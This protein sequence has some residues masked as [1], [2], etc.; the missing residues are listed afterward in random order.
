MNEVEVEY[1]INTGIIGPEEGG[2]ADYV[3]QIGRGYTT[4]PGTM[5]PA[6]NFEMVHPL[7]NG[8][9]AVTY[10]SE[11]QRVIEDEE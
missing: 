1:D 5:N 8:G 10:T 4:V 2:L 3:R 11:G 6:D 7:V 9:D